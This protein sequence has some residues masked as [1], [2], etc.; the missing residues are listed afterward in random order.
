MWGPKVKSLPFH[1]HG[2]WETDLMEQPNPMCPVLLSC[3]SVLQV[4]V[5][6]L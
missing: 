6:P 3:L 1:G 2:H 5:K 4:Q